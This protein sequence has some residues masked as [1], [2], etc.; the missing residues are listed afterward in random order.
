M[1]EHEQSDDALAE[2]LTLTVEVDKWGVS[3]RNHLGLFHRVHGPAYISIENN[4][5]WYRNSKLHREDGPAIEYANGDNW[6]FQND[7][8]HRIDGPAFQRVSGEHGWFIYGEKLTE[9]EF[10]E[11]VKSV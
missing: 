7:E 1:N 6:W 3:Y 10:N 2:L 9:E 4:K 11:R 5:H 8:P